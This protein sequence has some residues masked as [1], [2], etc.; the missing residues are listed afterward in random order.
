MSEPIRMT[1]PANR[2]KLA[3]LRIGQESAAARFTA[4]TAT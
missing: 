4:I 3:E 2:E 1:L